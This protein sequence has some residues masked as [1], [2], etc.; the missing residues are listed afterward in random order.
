MKKATV[1]AVAI[2]IVGSLGLGYLAGNGGQR[3]V[4]STSFL[5]S[6]Q[7]IV[8]TLTLGS[9]SSSRSGS[10]AT[11]I[12]YNSSLGIELTMS[13]GK[14]MI[15][16]GEGIPMYL[17]LEN[18]LARQ[19]NLSLPGGT[20]N[21]P[22]LEPCN[23][24]P[25]GVAIFRGNYDAGNLSRGQALGFLWGPN[26]PVNCPAYGY[27]FSMPPMSSEVTFPTNATFSA[28]A[29]MTYWGYWTHDKGSV[30]RPFSPG[31]YTVEGEDWWG[32]VT[33][34]H[35]EVV[36]D[37]SPLDCATIASN[38]SYVGYTNGSASQ[39]PLK[40]DAYYLSERANDTVVLAL[41]N[42]GNTNLTT[43]DTASVGFLY[44]P[45]IFNPNSP[46]A[47]TWRYY[48]PNGTLGYPAIFYPNQCVLISITLNSFP[49]SP[50]SIY[51]NDN[52]TQMFTF[53]PLPRIMQ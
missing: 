44:S 38:S 37:Q 35:F 29:N 36:Q 51:F 23:P 52:Q 22:R 1:T 45:Y 24:L 28:T 17:A 53:G 30:F 16:Q 41:S 50:L 21:P 5:T 43:Y 11:S 40:L 42:T 32:Q 4:T 14:T 8:S 34:L 47:Q 46:Q 49:Q 12:D 48:A 19:N 25:L 9:P 15:S 6:H 31:L 18:T 10:V 7:T 26:T 27:I 3:T 33:L 20:K 2:L 39:G 13:I